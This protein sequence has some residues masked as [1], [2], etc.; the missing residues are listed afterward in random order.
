MSIPNTNQLLPYQSDFLDTFLE[1]ASDYLVE[2]KL[3]VS[4]DTI[5]NYMI[6][7]LNYL[8]YLARFIKKNKNKIL[9]LV[10]KEILSKEIKNYDNSNPNKKE[11]YK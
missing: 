7:K 4:K 2:N 3:Q 9:E 10:E 1:E 8:T 6:L 11:N 5:E